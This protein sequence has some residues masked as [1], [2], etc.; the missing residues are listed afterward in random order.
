[1]N[2]GILH[3]IARVEPQPR[4]RLL[5]TWATGD[6]AT[7]DFAEDIARGGI[8]AALREDAKFATARVAHNGYVLEWPEP[9]GPQGEP[10]IDID[11]D[12]L[13]EMARRQQANERRTRL[14]SAGHGEDHAS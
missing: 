11:A 3:P 8:W 5:V 2:D 9:A 6:Q 10:R 13:F 7:V 14:V 4:Y 12:G 1:M